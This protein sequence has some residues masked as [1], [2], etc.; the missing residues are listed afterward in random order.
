MLSEAVSIKVV[1]E[2]L[3]HSLLCTT[4]DIYGHL[5]PEAFDGATNAMERVLA[6]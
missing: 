5:F 4:A 6:G 3:G 2:V 1:Q